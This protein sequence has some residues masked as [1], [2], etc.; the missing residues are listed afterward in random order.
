MQNFRHGKR[1]PVDHQGA[2]P[3]AVAPQEQLAEGERTAAADFQRAVSGP[4][5]DEG[6]AG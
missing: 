1:T 6:C 5:S 4:L 3:S 2:G